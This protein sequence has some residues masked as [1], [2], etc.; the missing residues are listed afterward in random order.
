MSTKPFTIIE[1]ALFMDEHHK[2]WAN[3]INT[4]E[5]NMGN[6]EKCIFGQLY[7][8]YIYGLAKHS[9]VYG[10]IVD[11]PFGVSADR[12]QWIQQ[13]KERLAI[14]TFKWAFGQVKQGKKVRRKSWPANQVFQQAT[15]ISALSTE[16]VDATNWELVPDKLTLA[17]LKVGAEFVFIYKDKNPCSRMSMIM[18]KVE[19]SGQYGVFYLDRQNNTVY[20]EINNDEVKLSADCPF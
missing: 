4:D 8:H 12:G 19:I 10:S 17:D 14:G 20:R 3:K 2:G 15:A 13:I 9:L 1:A 18:K 7:G 5:L 16:D 6:G 11:N